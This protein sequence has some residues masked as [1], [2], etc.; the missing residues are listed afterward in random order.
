MTIK[1]CTHLTIAKTGL[2]WNQKTQPYQEMNTMFWLGGVWDY[3]MKY[4][5]I[6]FFGFVLIFLLAYAGAVAA[7]TI[8]WRLFL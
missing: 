1:K 8:H 6:A 4:K 3:R 5:T 2:R 7:G